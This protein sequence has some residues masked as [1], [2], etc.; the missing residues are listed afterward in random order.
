[1]RE[2]E[3]AALIRCCEKIVVVPLTVPIDINIIE[4]LVTKLVAFTLQTGGI[5][6]RQVEKVLQDATEVSPNLIL[7]VGTMV[8]NMHCRKDKG[9]RLLKCL[10]IVEEVPH[11]W[12]LGGILKQGIIL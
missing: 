10:M 8:A 4:G 9:N 2:F 5:F 7:L 1:V 6:L 11:L 3:Y 12:K